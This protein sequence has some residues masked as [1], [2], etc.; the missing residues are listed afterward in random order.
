MS[1]FQNSRGRASV[2]FT[3]FAL[4]AVGVACGSKADDVVVNSH[5]TPDIESS[6]DSGGDTGANSST[7]AGNL[8]CDVDKVLHDNC[9]KCHSSPPVF[10]APMP[11]VTYGDLHAPSSSAPAEPVYK[12]V[13]ARIHDDMRPMPQP[14][15]PRLSPA[16]LATMDA[17][18]AGG[19]PSAATACNSSDGGAPPIVIPANC[20]PDIHVTTPNKHTMPK[21]AANKYVCYGFDVNVNDPR[22]VVA[23]TPKIDNPAIVHHVL[24]ME[25][26]EAVSPIP[27]ECAPLKQD[28]RL[29]SV[30]TPG[31]SSFTM[32]KE[33]GFALKPGTT[34]H[35]VVQIHYNN[36][37]GLEGEKDAS[38][39]DLC[40]DAPRPYEA[41]VMG[42][43]TQDITIPPKGT[44]DRTCTLVVPDLLGSVHLIAAMP[45]MH[46]LGTLI[47]TTLTPKGTSTPKDI[48]TVPNWDFNAQAWFPLDTQVAAG[49]TIT[50]RCAWKNPGSTPAVFGENT[51]QEMCYSITMYYPKV[52]FPGWAWVAP[53]VYTDA[54]NGCKETAP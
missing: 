12:R 17:W 48:G 34:T 45:H 7:I 19:A 18:I 8:P 5:S 24:L 36:V 9:R 47:S 40:T 10:G 33:A 4:V 11:L 52:Q 20:T 28:W 26:P 2:A 50:T 41:D 29:L 54:L 46:Q 38:G 30:W 42:F 32:P 39:F 49:D 6:F 27:T 53:A 16:D 37:K 14:P 35:Y 22:S 1:R 3:A 43:G 44:L 15:N 23:M 31:A 51:E 13:L 21:D 25:A